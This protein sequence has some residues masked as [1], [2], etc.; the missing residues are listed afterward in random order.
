MVGDGWG[1]FIVDFDEK[2]NYKGMVVWF[3]CGAVTTLGSS[4]ATTDVT[5]ML[6]CSLAHF[7]E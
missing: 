4:I 6:A 3:V 5:M 2:L 1:C 7:Q